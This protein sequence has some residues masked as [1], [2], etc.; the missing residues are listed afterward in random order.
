MHKARFSFP[1]TATQKSRCPLI[2]ESLYEFPVTWHMLCVKLN[3]RIKRMYICHIWYVT[4]SVI[5][6]YMPNTLLFFW[7]FFEHLIRKE[8]VTLYSELPSSQAAYMIATDICRIQ[9]SWTTAAP[10]RQSHNKPSKQGLFTQGHNV[11]S[12]TTSIFSYLAWFYISSSF[13]GKTE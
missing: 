4:C 6:L 9:Q 11:I 12:Q 3:I 5:S 8:E 2:S 7:A 13:Q 10:W 1:E